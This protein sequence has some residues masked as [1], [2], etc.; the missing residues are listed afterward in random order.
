VIVAGA[1]IIFEGVAV[2]V[3]VVLV[4]SVELVWWTAV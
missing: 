4:S 1:M 3:A 2:A